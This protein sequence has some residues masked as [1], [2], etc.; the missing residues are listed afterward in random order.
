ME[1][2]RE[3]NNVD[4]HWRRKAVSPCCEGDKEE[5][6]TKHIKREENKDLFK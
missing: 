3:R 4:R 2:T 6:N 1:K 5:R